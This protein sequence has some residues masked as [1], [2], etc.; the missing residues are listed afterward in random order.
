VP[1]AQE[2][3]LAV[4]EEALNTQGPQKS[5]GFTGKWFGHV[6]GETNR[7]ALAVTLRQESGQIRGEFAFDDLVFGRTVA[8]VTGRLVEGRL[9][10]ELSDFRGATNQLVPTTGQIVAAVRGDGDEMTG[11]W[12]TDAGTAGSFFLERDESKPLSTL[13]R[14][15]Q[16]QTWKTEIKNSSISS[17]AVRAKDLRELGKLFRVA[18]QEARERHERWLNEYWHGQPPQAALA[19]IPSPTIEIVE[20]EAFTVTTDLG[21]LDAHEFNQNLRAISFY[22]YKQGAATVPSHGLQVIISG[23]NGAA[24][25]P[26]AVS[27]LINVHG[28]EGTWATGVLQKFKSFFAERERHRGWLHTALADQLAGLFVVVPLTIFALYRLLPVL[29]DR[30]NRSSVLM[31]GLAI[32]VLLLI[33]VASRQFLKHARQVYPM[34]EVEFDR[35]ARFQKGRVFVWT[36]IVAL[37][38]GVMSSFIHDWLLSALRH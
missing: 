19:A 2:Q 28:L 16:T 22:S 10:A 7:G 3:P 36:F 37:F 17:F 4:N 18:A 15:N 12:R 21:S 25:A 13:P 1:N 8:L 38:L 32:Y 31:I 5:T 11:E 14:P 29:P 26:L 30:L 23:I 6:K 33:S 35:P 20:G 27:G 9:E 24:A 34:Y